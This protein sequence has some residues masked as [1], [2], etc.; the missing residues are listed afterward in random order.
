MQFLNWL[1]SFFSWVQIVA[2]PLIIFGIIGY[3]V[4][5]N[6]ST[7]IGL[8][9]GIVITII[10]LIWGIIIATNIWKKH[11]TEN[12]MSRVSSTLDID[13]NDDAN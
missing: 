3:I 6:L 7:L 10:G 9:A 11:G 12:F 8:L 2:S 4:Y 13:K 5:A 1:T